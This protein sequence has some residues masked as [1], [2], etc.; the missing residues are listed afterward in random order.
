MSDREHFDDVVVGAGP[1]GE[2]VAGELADAG[3]R[4]AIVERERVAGEC[5]FWACIPSKAL[6][7]PAETLRAAGRLPGSAQAL[8]GELDVA[9]VLRWRDRLVD[10]WDDSSHADWLLEKGIE[11]IRASGQLVA[12]GEVNAGHRRLVA[13][14]IV[15]ATGSKPVIPPIPGLDETRFWTNRDATAVSELPD[16]L[17]V[18]GGGAV[19]VELA[20]AFARFGAGVTLMESAERILASEDE[21]LSKA[22]AHALSA[23]GVE[24]RTDVAVSRVR[25]GEAEVRV[26]L[27]DGS[28]LRADKLLVAT[29][30]RSASDDLGLENVP[31]TLENGAIRVDRRLRAADGIFAVG[32]V[33]A[34]GMT[35][36]S[37]KYQARVAAAEILGH[38][39]DA[40]NSSDPRVIFSDPNAF[41]VGHTTKSAASEGIDVV[42]GSGKVGDTA[43]AGFL[44]S[45]G[46]GAGEAFLS[47]VGD[48]DTGCVIGASAVGP[49]AANW[50]G[51]AT[52]A[53]K[54][55]AHATE[56][57]QTIQPF[58]TLS[59]VFTSAAHGL[60]EEL[61]R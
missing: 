53:I 6:L 5:S 20:Q 51:Q 22:V 13:E 59:E 27:S 34:I 30:R 4:V 50:M 14:N 2:V 26:D 10:H 41:A 49:D 8:Q 52:L 45:N 24:L 28:E 18:L 47:L 23:D 21:R 44:S 48:R 46:D 42:V 35:T 15:I 57:A 40:D 43:A 7:K 19:G 33:N 1:A 12:G 61:K 3:R 55:G 36:H 9:A 32:D 31:V 37:G 16:R 29:G 54:L 38:G 25:G 17:L 58:P 56:L 11:L 60:C 39:Y